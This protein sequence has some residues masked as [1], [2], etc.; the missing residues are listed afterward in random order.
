[1]IGPVIITAIFATAM[2]VLFA[3]GVAAG[4]LV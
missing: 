2:L 4:R 1:M 3:V